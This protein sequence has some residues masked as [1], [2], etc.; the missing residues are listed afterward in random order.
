M[1]AQTLDLVLLGVL[2]VSALVGVL[3]GLVFE[4]LSLA[5]WV[6]AYVAAQALNPLVAPMLPVGAPD[7]AL[8]LGVAFALVFVLALIIW[9]LAARL[10]SA[11]IRATPLS[12]LDRLLG[13]LFGIMRGAVLLLA[14]ATLVLMSPAKKSPAWQ[15]SQLAQAL[16]AALRELRPLLPDD[17]ARHLPA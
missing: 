12:G 17:L 3:R 5:G 15:Q 11:L 2:I 14:V 10:V 6:A 8:N 4:V 1:T 7:S 9:G 16:G 13:A